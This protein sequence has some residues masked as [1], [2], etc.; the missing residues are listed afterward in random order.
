MI[1]VALLGCKS[2]AIATQIG[3]LRK[4]VRDAAFF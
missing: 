4:R 3:F 2:G 1:K